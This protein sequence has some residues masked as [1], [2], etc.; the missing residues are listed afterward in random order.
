MSYLLAKVMPISKL[1]LPSCF[2]CT[3]R[4]AEIPPQ[5]RQPRREGGRGREGPAADAAIASRKEKEAAAGLLGRGKA[6]IGRS[7][8]GS[9]R[10]LRRDKLN[11]QKYMSTTRAELKIVILVI[12]F[13][14]I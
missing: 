10:G 12:V 14:R 5:G 13:A 11:G 6:R 9:A 1:S 8:G 3:P 4:P 2:L 7:T